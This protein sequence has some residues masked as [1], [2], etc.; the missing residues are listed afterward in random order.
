M[1]CEALGAALQRCGEQK[2]KTTR[3]GKNTKMK[4]CIKTQQNM[5]LA[6]GQ[7]ACYTNGPRRIVFQ[8][9]RGRICGW[10]S[11]GMQRFSSQTTDHTHT[12]HHVVLL[13]GL[14]T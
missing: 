14:V 1:I 9:R 4:T 10:M 13:A 8:Q 12:W 6:P 3:I 5:P 2:H 7:E 11:G